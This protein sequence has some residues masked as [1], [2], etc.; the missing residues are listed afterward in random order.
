M[1]AVRKMGFTP[2]EAALDA[3][4]HAITPVNA[5]IAA[6]NRCS[7]IQALAVEMLS[8]VAWDLGAD[9]GDAAAIGASRR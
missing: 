7:Y 3:P 8:Y 9:G 6:I 5:Q 2:S 4:K 1:G